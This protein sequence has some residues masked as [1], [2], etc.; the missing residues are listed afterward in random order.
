VDIGDPEITIAGFRCT[1]KSE[2]AVEA[3]TPPDPVIHQVAVPDHIIGS[4][5]DKPERSSRYDSPKV[6]STGDAFL[7]VH[8]KY[9]EAAGGTMVKDI[10]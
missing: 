3:V 6:L 10:R 8:L 7:P 5:G 2:C 4:I 1:L 9:S